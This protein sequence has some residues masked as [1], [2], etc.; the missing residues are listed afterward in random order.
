MDAFMKCP[1]CGRYMLSRIEPALG[2]DWRNVWY[3]SCGYSSDCKGTTTDNKTH[4]VLEVDNGY[5]YNHQTA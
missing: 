2:V 5:R 1:K 4:K 3:C